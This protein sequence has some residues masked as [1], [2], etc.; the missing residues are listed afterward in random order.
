MSEFAKVITHQRFSQGLTYED[1]LNQPCVERETLIENMAAFQ[2]APADAQF[3][4][5]VV[6]QRPL[7]VIAIVGDNGGGRD[8]HR[9][10][11]IMVTIAKASGMDLRV[12]PKS[13]NL[14][15]MN[16]YLNQGKFQSIP[17]FAFLDE[18]LNP[19]GHWTER[20]KIATAFM[21]VIKSE[22]NTKNLGE[23]ELTQERNARYKPM[24]P[25]WRLET[26]RELKELLSEIR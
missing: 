26:V 9:A 12:F 3:F 7:K 20:P 11:P 22:P 23:K 16:F 19:L 10:L 17:V 6:R 1:F 4:K 8:V 18:N 5:D 2:L 24:W 25:A 13:K 21:D 14:D 15:I